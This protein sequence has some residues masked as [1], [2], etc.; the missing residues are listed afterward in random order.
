LSNSTT[1]E[2]ANL[3]AAEASKP[4]RLL[5]LDLGQKR[6]G[7]AITDEL[8]ISV[9]PLPPLRRTSWKQLVHTVAVL[10]RDFDAQSLVIGLPLSLDGTENTAAKE[11]KRQARNLERSLGLPVFLQDERL[12]SLEAERNLRAEGYDLREVRDRVDSEAAALILRD[13][14]EKV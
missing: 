8:R 12:T 10:V 3:Q 13:Y 7:V 4:G 2:T 11:I 6:V 14:L 5:A 9:R 1:T